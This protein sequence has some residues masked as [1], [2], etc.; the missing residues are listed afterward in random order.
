MNPSLFVD[1]QGGLLSRVL[2]YPYMCA[3]SNYSELIARRKKK[4]KKCKPHSFHGFL[5]A[6]LLPNKNFLLCS[7]FGYSR[8]TANDLQNIG[9]KPLPP[10]SMMNFPPRQ[11]KPVGYHHSEMLKCFLKFIYSLIG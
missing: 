10:M 7:R 4:R 11:R 8:K 6:V 2:L 3:E 1:F 9:R 5:S